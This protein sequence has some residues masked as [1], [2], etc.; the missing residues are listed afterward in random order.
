MKKLFENWRKYVNESCCPDKVSDTNVDLRLKASE[1]HGKGIFAGEKIAK[2]ADLGTSHI[3]KNGMWTIPDLGRWHNHSDNPSCHNTLNGS[4]KDKTYTRNLVA[5]R[6]IEPGEEI[7][8]NYRLQPDL[9]QPG[10]WAIK[11]GAK[12]GEEKN[13]SYSGVILDEESKQKLLSLDI[14]E[15]WEQIAHHM[16]ITMGSLVHKKGKHDFS[17]TYPVGSEVQLSVI[18]V[19]QDERA[20]A[21]KVEPP[22]PI[23]TKSW[24]HVTVAVNRDEGGK[25]FHSNK[26]PEENFEPLSGITL[27]G[28]VEEVPQ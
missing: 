2:G 14:P 24:P 23:K 19:G 4:M 13:I 21:V 10:Q 16:T 6:D 3:R 12:Q 28:T 17:K 11:E 18:A 7:T 27:I 8:V 20:M 25:P 22:S 1:I 9:E 5:S 15:G 26:I